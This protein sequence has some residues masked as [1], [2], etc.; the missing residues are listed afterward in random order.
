M[1]LYYNKFYKEINEIKMV[2]N[3][4]KENYGKE[5]T[6][7][8]IGFIQTGLEAV[9]R[10][11]CIQ[12]EDLLIIGKVVSLGT[13][14]GILKVDEHRNAS[15]ERVLG[16]YDMLVADDLTRFKIRDR[17]RLVGLPE[18]ELVYDDPREPVFSFARNGGLEISVH[19]KRRESWR[20]RRAYE[21]R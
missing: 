13:L 4:G 3:T 6:S 9:A 8:E 19:V 18:P 17:L 15:G 1:F 14:N 10:H 11:Y 16:E 20:T 12:K 7:R 21:E 2:A 5:I